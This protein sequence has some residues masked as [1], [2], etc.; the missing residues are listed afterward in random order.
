[1]TDGNALRKRTGLIIASG[2]IRFAMS[3]ACFVFANT[4]IIPWSSWIFWTAAFV[5]LFLSLADAG[6]KSNTENL[7]NLIKEGEYLI[8][9]LA[10]KQKR[11]EEYIKKDI[12]ELIKIGAF[13]GA[14]ISNDTIILADVE[15]ITDGTK[16]N[17]KMV[18]VPV[19]S[20]KIDLNTAIEQELSNLPGVSVALAKKAIELRAQTGGFI[21][22]Q[23]FNQRLGLMPHF[24][25]QIESIAFV[26][27]ITPPEP[28]KEN[29]GRVIDI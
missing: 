12:R 27:P 19:L 17:C 13:P 28:P 11:K 2:C 4:K 20:Q 6:T 21:S 8:P 29:K 25:T 26:S 3:V 5:F 24:V 7:F 18:S 15:Q 14:V 16:D 1:M 9:N 10:N 22:V 23:D